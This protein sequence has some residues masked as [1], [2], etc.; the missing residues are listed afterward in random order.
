MFL[1]QLTPSARA[2]MAEFG[3]ATM[4]KQSAIG[5]PLLVSF[6]GFFSYKV[7]AIPYAFSWGLNQSVTPAIVI[8]DVVDPKKIFVFLFYNK[9]KSISVISLL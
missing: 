1:P 7:V 3:L 9:S 5:S 6:V 8:F 4:P 2:S